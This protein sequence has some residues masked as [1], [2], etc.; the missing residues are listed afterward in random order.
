MDL[1]ARD[2]IER[3]I[4]TSRALDAAQSELEDA[5]REEARAENE[6]RKA[7]ASAYLATEGRTVAEREA[8]VD[9]ATDTVRYAAHLAGGMTKARLE[10]V[11]NRRTQ[12][13]TLQTIAN[14]V[15]AEIELAR[16]GP[17]I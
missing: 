5:V 15:R 4:E 3:M 17:D 16:T 14:S 13:S 6:Y 10:A 1:T 8:R 12:L 7:R 2:L 9:Q 11:R